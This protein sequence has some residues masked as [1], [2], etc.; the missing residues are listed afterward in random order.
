MF[1]LLDSIVYVRSLLRKAEKAAAVSVQGL[2]LHVTINYLDSRVM[3]HK[4]QSD[5]TQTPE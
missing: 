3:V 2:S 4:L 5:G 1:Y